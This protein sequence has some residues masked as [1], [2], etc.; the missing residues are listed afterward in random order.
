MKAEEIFGIIVRAIGIWE[1]AAG[2][3]DIAAISAGLGVILAIAVKGAVGGLLLFNADA[4]VRAAYRTV[5]H[6]LE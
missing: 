3:E 1:I 6:D 2:L 4:I 5:S